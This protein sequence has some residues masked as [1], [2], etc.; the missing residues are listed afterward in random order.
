MPELA[1]IHRPM[2]ADA[3]P[4]PASAAP[5]FALQQG[6]RAGLAAGALAAL[7]RAAGL[8]E[9]A[10]VVAALPE[11]CLFHRLTGLDCPG[12]GMTR[13]FLSLLRGDVPGALHLH[14]F[15]LPLF[16]AIL[17]AA[18]A[19]PALRGRMVRSRVGAALQLLALAALL[20]WWA[21]VKLLPRLS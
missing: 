12:C 17:F 18:F 4:R 10:R 16:A 6:L 15:S 19:P 8:F 21:Q 7:A 2:L 3:A 14:P 5:R 13:A 20:A 1:P 11:L 9:P